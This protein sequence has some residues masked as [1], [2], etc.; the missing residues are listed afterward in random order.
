MRPLPKKAAV[1][2]EGWEEIEGGATHPP[3]ERGPAT[4]PAGWSISEGRMRDEAAR[5]M[6]EQAQPDALAVSAGHED[7]RRRLLAL[8]RD[9]SEF[10]AE[11]SQRFDRIEGV[12][13]RIEQMLLTMAAD[14]RDLKTKSHTHD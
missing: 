2:P 12:L 6:A 7:T 10:K 13:A 5:E 1:L 4:I 9:V 8:A 3:H 11:T 14:I